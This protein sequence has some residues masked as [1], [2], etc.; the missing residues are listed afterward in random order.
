[1]LRIEE[2][3][4]NDTEKEKLE[5]LY[6]GDVWQAL[7]GKSPKEQVC[8]TIVK[9]I[10]YGTP[11]AALG[12]YSFFEYKPKKSQIAFET[13]IKGENNKLFY[14]SSFPFL[15]GVENELYFCDMFDWD[16][17]GVEGYIQLRKG[18]ARAMWMFNPLFGQQLHLLKQS[19]GENK[20]KQKFM[21]AGL[22]WDISPMPETITEIDSGAY[23]DSALENFLLQNQDK[24]KKD[25][26]TAKL[27]MSHTNSLFAKDCEDAYEFTS[28]IYDIQTFSC[29]E[30]K[31][32]CLKI[33]VLQGCE[34]IESEDGLTVNLYVN[35]K[36]FDNYTPKIGDNIY[37]LMQLTAYIEDRCP[38]SSRQ[39]PKQRQTETEDKSSVTNQFCILSMWFCIII[40][41]LSYFYPDTLIYAIV[42][43]PALFC[44][45]V[46]IRLVLYFR[47][48]FFN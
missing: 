25:F 42:L 46:L 10:H 9:S 43:Y 11:V 38:F 26:P 23:Y 48:I 32:Y 5:F 29:L 24:T 1:M 34:N 15:P 30:N 17:D 8:K 41:I 19:L 3:V 12:D 4:L 21:I 40:G 20:G 31:I 35:E 16:E 47:K 6:G 2:T 36:W 14:Q 44:L 37:G 28:D 45:W 22:G 39:E 13:I 7:W 33:K 18:D 27:D